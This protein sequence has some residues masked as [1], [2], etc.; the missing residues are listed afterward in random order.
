MAAKKSWK[1]HGMLAGIA[2]CERSEKWDCRARL[3]LGF[4]P[5][6]GS[7]A[8]ENHAALEK[9]GTQAAL[10]RGRTTWLW[11]SL[12]RSLGSWNARCGSDAELAL[13]AVWK[14]AGETL[15]ERKG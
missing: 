9:G 12:C 13:L 4:K 1:K 2:N 11:G 8:R 15:Q 14:N 7:H 6:C 3:V 5:S 10:V